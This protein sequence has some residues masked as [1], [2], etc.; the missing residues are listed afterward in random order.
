MIFA[1]LTNK[2]LVT[3]IVVADE[4]PDD[5]YVEVN[6]EQLVDIAF[7]YD[8]VSETFTDPKIPDENF[9]L[10]KQVEARTFYAEYMRSVYNVE[11]TFET[12]E[13]ISV[14]ATATADEL[15]ALIGEAT[16]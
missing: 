12:P 7:I 2:N 10:D 9:Y 3:N 4:K 6:D 1:E 5:N 11:V 16:V 13:G 8:E 14:P 15:A